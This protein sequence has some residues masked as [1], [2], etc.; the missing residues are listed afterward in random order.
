MVSTV[1][2]GPAAV[3]TRLLPG[4]SHPPGLGGLGEGV[5]EVVEEGL[6]GEDAT[7]GL[8]CTVR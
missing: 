5:A 8:E 1:T 3:L 6:G 2:T 7:A 4:Q